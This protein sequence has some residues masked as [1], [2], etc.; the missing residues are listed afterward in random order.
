MPT[1][2]IPPRATR[3]LRTSANIPTKIGP[4]RKPPYPTVVTTELAAPARSGSMLPAT[5][6]AMG[7]TAESATPTTRNPQTI[8]IGALVAYASAIPM[9]V[10]SPAARSVGWLLKRLMMPAETRRPAGMSAL[11]TYVV[12]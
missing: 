4:K 9:A 7:T 8:R 10:T 6:R 11:K 2:T 5:E 3:R 12:V 1:I